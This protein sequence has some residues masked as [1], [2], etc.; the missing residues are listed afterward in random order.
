MHSISLLTVVQMK[1]MMWFR[2]ACGGKVAIHS[3]SVSPRIPKRR[4]IH[5]L[6][7]PRR[8]RYESVR[9]NEKPVETPPPNPP[10]EII[11]GTHPPT[12]PT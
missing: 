2:S 1:C 6:T 4:T 11:P 3:Y 7:S 8:V 9:E 10:I 12:P 5:F